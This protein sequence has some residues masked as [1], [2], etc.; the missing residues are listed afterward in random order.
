MNLR[1]AIRAHG[2]SLIEMLF[3]VGITAVIAAIAVP[4]MRNTMGDFRIRGDAR[5]V[6][7]A[8]SLAKLRAAS[9]FTNVRMYVDLSTNSFHIESYDK[10]AV[11]WNT[12]GGTTG[13]SATDSFSFGAITMPPPNTQAVIGQAP[14]CKTA[15]NAD[16]AG[17]ACVIF[18]SRGVPVDSTGAPTGADALYVT[19]GTAVYGVTLS[20]TGLIQQWRTNV[21]ATNW[22][23]Q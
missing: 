10:T 11:A 21:G 6:T 22:V 7:N 12:E 23:L 4:M 3:V 19:D 15:A 2:F 17:T 20:A 8:V 16:I 9:D 18:N 14:L 1:P 5:S 13:L